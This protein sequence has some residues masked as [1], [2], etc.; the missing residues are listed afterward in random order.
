MADWHNTPS[1]HPC[2]AKHAQY[3][4]SLY[5]RIILQYSSAYPV[6]PS[7]YHLIPLYPSAYPLTPYIILCPSQSFLIISRTLPSSYLII[8]T[9][10]HRF[11]RKDIADTI[12]SCIVKALSAAQWLVLVQDHY[13][14]ITN[15]TPDECKKKYLGRCGWGRCRLEIKL[16]SS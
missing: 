15:L 6:Y 5:H 16:S 3:H 1:F 8:S 10:Y 12:P 14:T 4:L 9:F 13:K 2:Q 11:F 7:T